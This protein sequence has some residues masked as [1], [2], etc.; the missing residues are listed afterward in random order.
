MS[1]TPERLPN[2]A[3]TQIAIRQSK[4]T[5]TMN[6]HRSCRIE[7]SGLVSVEK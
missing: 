4:R 1:K 5:E 3:G 2:P 7:N 6:G